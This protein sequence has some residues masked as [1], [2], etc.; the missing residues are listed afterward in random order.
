DDVMQLRRTNRQHLALGRLDWN[1][2]AKDFT[3]LARPRTGGDDHRIY[4]DPLVADPYRGHLTPNNPCFVDRRARLHH[5][6]TLRRSLDPGLGQL[7]IVQMMIAGEVDR[8]TQVGGQGRLE[9]AR[10]SVR[11]PGDRV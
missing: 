11:E 10:L 4:A 3:R 7:A 8:A 6:P 1:D 5:D 2:E 9:P